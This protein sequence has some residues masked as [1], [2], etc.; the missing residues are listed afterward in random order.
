MLGSN[1]SGQREQ[2]Q[3]VRQDK[4]KKEPNEI[5]PLCRKLP[6]HIPTY[7]IY[8][9]IYIYII[10]LTENILNNTILSM[11]SP[12]LPSTIL[13][14]TIFQQNLLFNQRYP[15]SSHQTINILNIQI[16]INYMLN[17]FLRLLPSGPLY[18]QH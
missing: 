10:H 9:Y 5:R 14:F 2:V 12:P 8:V 13:F 15:V 6:P 18:N 16:V 7:N 17:R 11:H 4:R 1:W 3:F